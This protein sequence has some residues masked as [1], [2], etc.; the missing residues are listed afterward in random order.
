LVDAQQVAGVAL[1][2]HLEV[3]CGGVAPGDG[4]EDAAFG[5]EHGETAVLLGEQ[6]PGGF[7]G[8]VVGDEPRTHRHGELLGGQDSVGSHAQRLGSQLRGSGVGGAVGDS[9]KDHDKK[10]APAQRG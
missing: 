5:G 10:K 8:D 1:E 4:G 3:G 6:G 7:G 9:Q 2:E